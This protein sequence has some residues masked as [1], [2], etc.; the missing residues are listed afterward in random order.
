MVKFILSCDGSTEFDVVDMSC[1]GSTEFD[2]VDVY[3]AEGES[4]PWQPLLRE[5]VFVGCEFGAVEGGFIGESWDFR[6]LILYIVG[7]KV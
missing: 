6:E 1:D 5:V 7:F 4:D 2:V 3:V